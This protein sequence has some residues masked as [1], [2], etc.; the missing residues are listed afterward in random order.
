MFK[1]T[2]SGK[3]LKGRFLKELQDPSQLSEGVYLG[4]KVAKY[5]SLNRKSDRLCRN[6]KS[7]YKNNHKNPVF[8]FFSKKSSKS[9]SH[10][11]KAQNN[12]YL[13]QKKHFLKISYLK[14]LEFKFP[15][16]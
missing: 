12:L 9:S 6:K 15:I 13:S 14:Y 8:P 1:N 5:G 11:Q 4:I 16:L 7:F 3:K 2:G 10:K